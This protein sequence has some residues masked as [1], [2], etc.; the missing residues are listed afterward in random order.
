MAAAHL[1]VEEVIQALVELGGEAKWS[2]IRKLVTK[3]R[4][5][6]YA[7]YKDWLNYRTTMFQL[8]QQHCEGY[9]KFIG[10]IL[11]QKVHKGRFLLVSTQPK[12][13][14]TTGID[15]THDN[16][17]D[18]VRILP[19]SLTPIAADIAEPPMRMSSEIYRILRDTKLAREVKVSHGFQCQVCHNPPLKLSDI[20]FY[21]EVHHIKPL[22]SPHNGPDIQ[23]NILCVCPNCHVLLDYGA[24]LLDLGQLSTSTTHTI[25][26]KYV[27]YHN[28]QV[29]RK[30]KIE[31]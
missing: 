13:S 21:A 19:M 5:N 10:P 18:F 4:G 8:V 24:I 6:S 11:F 30:V 16:D 26:R 17:K 27:D 29:F 20:K 15:I 7:P 25:G 2:D 23:E 31:G 22:G 28:Q 12:V 9:E 14:L 1:C 3:K